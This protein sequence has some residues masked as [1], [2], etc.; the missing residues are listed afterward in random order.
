MWPKDDDLVFVNHID[1]WWTVGLETRY[2]GLVKAYAY[3]DRP[4]GLLLWTWTV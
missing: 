3:N 4:Y 1:L 2:Y